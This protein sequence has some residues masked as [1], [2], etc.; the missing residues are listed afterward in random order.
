MN[1]G[2]LVTV[3]LTRRPG[4]PSPTM[5]VAA[6][7]WAVS[8][9]SLAI[10][11]LMAPSSGPEAPSFASLVS[12]GLAVLLPVTVGAILVV[13]LSR[14]PIGWLLL[15]SGLSLAANLGASGLVGY[16]FAGIP[17]SVVGADWI[18]L[19]AQ[20]TFL[21]LVVGLGLFVPLVYP[22][23]HLPSPRWRLVALLGL[24]ALTCGT[25]K[26]L[27]LPFPPGT[28]PPTVANPLAVG[29]AA[30]DLASIFDSV[31]NLI[32]VVALPLVVASLVSRYRSATGIER[33]QLKWLVAVAAIAVPALTVGIVLGGETSGILGGI[34]TIAWLVGLFGFGLLPVAIGVAVLR[35]RLYDIDRLISRTIGWAIVTGLLIAVFVIVILVTQTLL[36]SITSSNALA[37]AASTLVVFALFQPLRRR[38]QSRVD[39]RFNRSHYDAERVVERFA[40]LLRDEID[41]RQLAIEI[42]AAV[43]R[44]VQP[45]SVS[46]WLRPPN[47]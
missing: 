25:I 17:G 40:G 5:V 7:V 29:G 30:A 10:G 26:N 47:R 20:V 43:D 6:M 44:T 39:R 42:G 19:L 35:Y 34:A 27:L 32:G 13:R 31:T 8:A 23:G 2:S 3:L 24:V 18:A 14:N 22:S 41:L 46:I 21:P 28:Y 33:Q 15:L 45:S 11:V 37:V 38:V 9:A 1:S 36:A 16:A 4:R 12:S